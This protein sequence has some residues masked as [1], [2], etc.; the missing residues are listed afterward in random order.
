MVLG[1]VEVE[2]EVEAHEVLQ[3]EVKWYVK[4]TM[5]VAKNA[6]GKKMSQGAKTMEVARIAEVAATWSDR[7]KLRK[8]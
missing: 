8:S 5:T 6:S 4:A 2:E 7:R 1:L 3:E